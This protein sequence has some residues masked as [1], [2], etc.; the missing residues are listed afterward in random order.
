[1][2]ANTYIAIDRKTFKVYY[3]YCADNE[4]NPKKEKLIGKG[5]T[6]EEA[7]EI[8]EREESEYGIRFC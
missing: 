5:R 8:A 1:M 6:I 3:C 4:F 7:I 2:S